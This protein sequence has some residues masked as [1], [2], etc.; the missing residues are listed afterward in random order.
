MLFLDGSYDLKEEQ[1]H[2]VLAR[3]KP[4]IKK[5]LKV[6]HL[7]PFL[8]ERWVLTET[9]EQHLSSTS[10]QP[11]EQVSFRDMQILCRHSFGHNGL[12][13]NASTMLA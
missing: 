13:L 10:Y 12:N 11:Q 6:K 5:G 4:S 2:R 8:K 1:V 9:E 3:L 7:L